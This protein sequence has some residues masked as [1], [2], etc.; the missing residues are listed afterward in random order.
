MAYGAGLIAAREAGALIVDP[1]P[2]AAPAIAEAFRRYP[3]IGPVLPAL[4]Y[5]AGEIEALRETVGRSAAEFV[6]AATP[7]DLA[8]DTAI[9]RPVLRVGYGY[10]DLD[11]PGLGDEV[12]RFVQVLP[13]RGRVSQ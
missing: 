6:V 5:S 12:D 2:V 8:R 7:I 3:H 10:E 1:R 9:A 4:G 13:A 11:S